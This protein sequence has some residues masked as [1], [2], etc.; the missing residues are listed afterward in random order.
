MEPSTYFEIENVQI[1]VD[2]FEN[3]LYLQAEVK[4]WNGNE[5][6]A[7]VQ[8]EL[9]IY[10]SGGYQSIGSYNLV[11]GGQDGDIISENGIYSRLTNPTI[12]T[13]LNVS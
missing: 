13:L 10:Q 9:S 6:I 5:N 3:E 4:Y 1:E 7:F 11:D 2:K 8:A 12:A